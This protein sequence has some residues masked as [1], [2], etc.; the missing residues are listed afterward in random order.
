MMFLAGILRWSV[1]K[2]LIASYRKIFF[3]AQIASGSHKKGCNNERNIQYLSGM[4][5]VGVGIFAR[6]R[7]SPYVLGTIESRHI[8]TVRREFQTVQ[9]LSGIPRRQYL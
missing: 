3:S 8:L 7:F 4:Q 1:I 2:W 9:Y 5:N 6:I